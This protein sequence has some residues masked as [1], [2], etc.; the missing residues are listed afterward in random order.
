[1]FFTML[2][3][4][5]FR[6][7]TH[8]A[9]DEAVLTVLHWTRHVSVITWV[10]NS[11]NESSIDTWNAVNHDQSQRYICCRGSNKATVQSTQPHRCHWQLTR[12][13]WRHRISVATFTELDRMIHASPRLHSCVF[14][15]WCM[16]LQAQVEYVETATE[17][18]R[19]GSKLMLK[20][21]TL[22]SVSIQQQTCLPTIVCW[23][24]WSHASPQI[25]LHWLRNPGRMS[26]RLSVTITALG[27]VFWPRQ[28]DHIDGC[29]FP[30]REIA[31]SCR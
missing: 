4:R 2:D 10:R 18:E 19:L 11:I 22:E 15:S 5:F 13:C 9:V 7:G 21:T 28:R 26:R 12:N 23:W 27:G 16:K 6:G 29:F 20:I 30:L 24:R 3:H 14:L 31:Q 25:Y 17:L 8:A 1:M